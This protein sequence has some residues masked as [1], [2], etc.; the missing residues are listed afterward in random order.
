MALRVELILGCDIWRSLSCTGRLSL[1]AQ[2]IAE[3]EAALRRQA[4]DLGWTQERHG[5]RLLDSCPNCSAL[6]VRGW[7]QLGLPR[8]GYT[9]RTRAEDPAPRNIGE[10]AERDRRRSQGEAQRPPA[11]GET[12]T[13]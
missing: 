9:V 13:G 5:D 7:T 10:T 6:W 3:G 2:A 11:A 8:G 4:K 1:V 12:G